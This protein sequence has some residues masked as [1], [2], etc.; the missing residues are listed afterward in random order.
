MIVGLFKEGAVLPAPSPKTP[1][2]E[3]IILANY[4]PVSNPPFLEK[5]VEKEAGVQLMN[6]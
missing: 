2:L 3:L 1:S 6:V 4:H 5:V